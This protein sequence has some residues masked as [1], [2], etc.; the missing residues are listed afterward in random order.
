MHV[1]GDRIQVFQ[2]HDTTKT[3]ISVIGRLA[4]FRGRGMTLSGTNINVDAGTN[5]L[6]IDG[7]GEMM[8]PMDRDLK[9]EP[10]QHG[11][12]LTITWQKE[13]DF[14]GLNAR[15]HERVVAWTQNQRLQTELL[16]VQ[17]AE[18]VDFRNVRSKSRPETDLEQIV[19]R[20]GVFMEGRTYE[21]NISPQP[22]SAGGSGFVHSVSLPP[23]VGTRP[24]RQ[25]SWEEFQAAELT[26]NR[27]TGAIFAQ[28]PG[29]ITTI[30]LKSNDLLAA[31]RGQIQSAEAAPATDD[32]LAYLHVEFPQMM[33]GNIEVREATFHE[34]VRCVYEEVD[35]WQARLDV[36]DP[37]SL[38][39]A[40]VLLTADRLTV[41]EAPA[42]V[43]GTKSI[44]LEALGNV[45]AENATFTARA[46]RMTF[47]EAKEWLILEGNGYAPAELS[48]QEYVGAS[49]RRYPAGKICFWPKTKDVKIIDGRSLQVDGLPVR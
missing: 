27:R 30:R 19:C 7:S 23:G 44:E 39:E 20:G 24:R 4:V 11:G 12:V 49:S 36:H 16:D 15:F 22:A 28:G 17:F 3:V 37:D 6:W 47:S 2:A 38:S 32:K 33:T 21:K 5:R 40:G 34:R 29:R 8:L 48:F 18:K 46:N 26:I 31:R 43:A 41:A 42:P 45:T 25:E 10:V 13:M 9:G 35:S 14:D 1:E